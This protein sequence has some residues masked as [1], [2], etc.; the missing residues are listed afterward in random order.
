VSWVVQRKFENYVNIPSGYIDEGISGRY[1]RGALKF[2]RAKNL[3][4]WWRCPD[5]S[6][7]YFYDMDILST[8]KFAPWS[9]FSIV[10]RVMRQEVW[11]GNSD[12]RR[13]GKEW[14]T[15]FCFSNEDD[16]AKF[17]LVWR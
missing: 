13:Y 15:Y 14:F 17:L 3:V 7:D 11:E 4:Y 12:E 6:D 1:L 5:F 9:A 10:R 8:M 2:V 16:R